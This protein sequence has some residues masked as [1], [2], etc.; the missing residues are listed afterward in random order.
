MKSLKC[1]FGKHNWKVLVVNRDF[2]TRYDDNQ[3]N[4]W[5]VDFS[6]CERC[7]KRKAFD[8]VRGNHNGV[9]VAKKHWQNE[10]AVPYGSKYFD[11]VAVRLVDDNPVKA[12]VISL[13]VLKGGKHED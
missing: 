12:E 4:Y 6:V 1:M 11:D 2:S 8:N 13:N 7:S 9:D 3:V 10:G 5:N